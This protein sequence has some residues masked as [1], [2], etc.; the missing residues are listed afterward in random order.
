MQPSLR[1]RLRLAATSRAASM[2]GSFFVLGPVFGRQRLL[3]SAHVFGTRSALNL[4]GE[5]FCCVENVQR[6]VLFW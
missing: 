2:D 6:A 3:V 1:L 4:S 5:I